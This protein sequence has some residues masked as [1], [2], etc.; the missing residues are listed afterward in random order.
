[1]TCATLSRMQRRRLVF[2]LGTLLFLLAP[3]LGASTARADSDAQLW[4]SAQL[5]LRVHRM[6]QIDIEQ[7]VRLDENMSHVGRVLPDITL[8]VRARDWLRLSVGYR[9][10]WVNDNN[11]DI[12]HRAYADARFDD[13]IGAFAWVT[14]VRYQAG[15]R[16]GEPT[17]HT[18]RGLFQVGIRND[19]AVTPY[20]STE[21]FTDVG[22]GGGADARAWRGTLGVEVETRRHSVDVHYRVEVP[23][24]D[25]TDPTLHILGL[26]YG[27]EAKFY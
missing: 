9:L 18:L 17:R 14:R 19:S 20:A 4:L 21:L 22:H 7:G 12:R 8:G 11:P 10:T 6:V 16:A 24:S 25:S 5:R 27:Y 3:G 23:L 15:I 2:A 13:A 26:S 1:M